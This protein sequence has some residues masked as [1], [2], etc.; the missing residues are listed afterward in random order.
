MK[1]FF[2]ILIIFVF[3]VFILPSKS[4]AKETLAVINDN[5]TSPDVTYYLYPATSDLIAQDIVNRVNL[6]NRIAAIPTV[7]SV[8]KLKR[9][10]VLPQGIKLINEYKYTYNIN[11]EALRKVSEKLDV[12]YILL[13]TSGMDIQ[14]SFLKETI[15][16]K[17]NVPGEDVVNP[18]YKIIT[19][20][21]LLDPKNEFII[22]QKNYQKD[23]PSK[24][25]DLINQNF[26]PVYTQ[27]TRIKDYSEQLSKSVT[28]LIEQQIVPELIPV[29]K[30]FKE[31]VSSKLFKKSGNIKEIKLKIKQNPDLKLYNYVYED[32]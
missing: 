2:K 32:L 13:V 4:F 5:F 20:I 27:M 21:T 1:V 31:T 22:F 25:F 26:S 11:Y 7:N 10:N 19:R 15:W 17:L 30:N 9:N 16:N 12:N 8:E 24:E 23:I 18:S 3:L 6:N 29:K 14:S 28:P